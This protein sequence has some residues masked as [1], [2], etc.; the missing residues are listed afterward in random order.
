MKD[1]IVEPIKDGSSNRLTVVGTEK[2]E[3]H[4]FFSIDLKEE[5]VKGEKYLL[6]IPFNASLNDRLNGY[7]R[8]SYKN[9]GSDNKT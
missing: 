7:Y 4:D 8:S 9:K 5:L 2:K 3:S 1:I 6:F